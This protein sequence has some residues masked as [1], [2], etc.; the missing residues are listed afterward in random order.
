[1]VVGQGFTG[2]G[3]GQQDS[4]NA[5]LARSPRTMC[6]GIPPE[7]GESGGSARQ[8]ECLSSSHFEW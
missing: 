8:M 4:R 3:A 1:M 2:D 5:L 7:R 6:E